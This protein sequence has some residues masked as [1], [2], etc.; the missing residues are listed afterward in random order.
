MLEMLFSGELSVTNNDIETIVLSDNTID[1]NPDIDEGQ[2]EEHVSGY[3]HESHLLP[4]KLFDESSHSRDRE[5]SN[6]EEVRGHARDRDRE[7]GQQPGNFYYHGFGNA[8]TR[9]V[10]SSNSSSC[11]SSQPSEWRRRR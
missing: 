1:L 7:L 8:P 11:A 2:G 4:R 3:K 6:S 9:T 5:S 10:D